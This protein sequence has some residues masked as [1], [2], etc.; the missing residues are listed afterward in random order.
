[1]KEKKKQ[2]ARAQLQKLE[3]Q[4]STLAE[5]LDKEMQLWT[6]LEEDPQVQRCEKEEERINT[7]IQ[8]LK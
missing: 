3:Q 8:E 5:L 2:E 1:M 6:R 4:V 7:M